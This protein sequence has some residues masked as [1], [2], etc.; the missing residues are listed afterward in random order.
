MGHEMMVRRALGA[1]LF[2]L[3]CVV[4]APAWSQVPVSS[5]AELLGAMRA[6]KG[7]ERIMLA[8]GD[9]GALALNAKRDR[10]AQYGSQVSLISAD[11]ARPASFSSVN[12]VGVENIAFSGIAF[13]YAFKL[14]DKVSARPFSFRGV[15]QLVIRDS[16]FIGSLASGTD[17]MADGFGT[18]IGLAIEASDSVVVERNVFRLW[19][20]GAVFQQSSNLTVRA[21]EVSEIRSD[22]MDFAQVEKVLIERNHFHDFAGQ[23]GGTDHPDMIQFWTNQTKA[24]S[25]GITISDNVLDRGVG[26]W[27]QS[28]FMRNEEVD[29]NRAGREMFYRDVKITG[30]VI[31]SGHLHGITVGQTD[32]LTI[33]NN[34]LIQVE[35]SP[36]LVHVTVPGINL[37][38]ASENVRV[39]NNITPRLTDF[40]GKLKD[41][42]TIA[43]NMRVQRNFPRAKD[44]YTNVFVDALAEGTVPLQKLQRLP[45][46]AGG[47]QTDIGAALT[48]FD[49][50]PAV[51]TVIILSAPAP[52]EGSANQ[53]LDASMVFGPAGK[54]DTAGASAV[55]DLGSGVSKTGM[56]VSYRFP[57]SG[58]YRV[59]VA[60]TLANGSRLTGTR[61]LFVE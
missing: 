23:K 36:S 45:P 37:N 44:F 50:K 4:A 25:V 20:R 46:E 40:A 6:A 31:R 41:G 17:T 24:P 16:R 18:G 28:I 9:Y 53:R 14:N 43:K 59:S 5:A 21:N 56:V 30:N 47:G 19:H 29:H 27:T 8:P 3:A 10:W 58:A 12:L 15:K 48:N 57:G 54:V 33:A 49:P 13:N 11:P 26:T 55:W 22:G 32:G 34:T 39:E 35:A 52:G 2:C 38:P 61:T 51:P 42:W 1:A 60:L 7:G